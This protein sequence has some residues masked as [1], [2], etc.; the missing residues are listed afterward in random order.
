M[1]TSGTA[2]LLEAVPLNGVRLKIMFA[3]SSEEYG[4]QLASEARLKRL[5]TNT[6]LSSPPQI[7]A[8]T[9]GQ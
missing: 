8:R 9:P 7:V 6:V 4:L 3:G 5:S 2:N 1:N